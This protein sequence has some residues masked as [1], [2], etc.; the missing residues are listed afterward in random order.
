M[1][2][3]SEPSFGVQVTKRMS[4]YVGPPSGTGKRPDCEGIANA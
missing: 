2:T 4:R 1:C 3:D